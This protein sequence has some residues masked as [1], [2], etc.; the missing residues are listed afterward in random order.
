MKTY[1]IFSHGFV[2]EENRNFSHGFI[3]LLKYPPTVYLDDDRYAC[4]HSMTMP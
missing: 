2:L 1:Y 3:W 4:H